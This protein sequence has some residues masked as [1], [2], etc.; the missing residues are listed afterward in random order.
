MS[1]QFFRNSL[2]LIASLLVSAASSD[3]ARSWQDHTRELPVI[4]SNR[5]DA[6]KLGDKV[7]FTGKVTLKKK[8]RR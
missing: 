4:T 2:F 7:T 6:E 3:D 1:K 5:M 8:A